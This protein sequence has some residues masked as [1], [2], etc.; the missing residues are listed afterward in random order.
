MRKGHYITTVEN[1][2]LSPRELTDLMVGKACELSIKRVP[3]TCMKKLLEIKDLTV[4]S[5]EKTKM[6]DGVS[7]HLCGG[8]ILGVAGVAGS[9]QK[10]L[11][12]AIAGLRKTTSGN[13]VFR[14][15]PSQG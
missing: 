15:N 14:T 6:L 13:I 10:E 4:I 9:G 2:N 12:E 7:F 3:G 1:K 8:E 11:C 5:A